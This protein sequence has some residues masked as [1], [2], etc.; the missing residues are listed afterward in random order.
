MENTDNKQQLSEP[1]QQEQGKRKMSPYGYLF[2]FIGWWFGFTGLYTM[3][4]VWPFP[5]IVDT[6]NSQDVLGEREVFHHGKTLRKRV[7]D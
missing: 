6:R 1:A 4:A 2:R 3:F 5:K 7:Q